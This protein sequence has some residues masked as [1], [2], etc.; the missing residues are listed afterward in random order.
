MGLCLTFCPQYKRRENGRPRCAGSTS[1]R[2]DSWRCQ[3]SLLLV[4]TDLL[5]K[6][7]R[8]EEPQSPCPP[9]S[10][11]QEQQR[12]LLFSSFKGSSEPRR[13]HECWPLQSRMASSPSPEHIRSN[14]FFQEGGL[15]Q[16]ISGQMSRRLGEGA[17]FK[18]R[19]PNSKP[20]QTCAA[21][22]RPTV[23]GSSCCTTVRRA[24]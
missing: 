21:A 5:A 24:S 6:P 10:L 9:V 7:G 2:S 22:S 12:N 3:K 11:V 1:S 13:R 18:C 15:A 17:P 23:S 16:L 4:C 8:T 19:I 20:G 14:P